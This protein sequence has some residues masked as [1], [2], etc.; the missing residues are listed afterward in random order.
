M[1]SGADPVINT[2]FSCWPWAHHWQRWID[3]DHGKLIS[4]ITHEPIGQFITQERRC[5]RCEKVQLRVAVG[6]K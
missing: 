5:N 2:D 3:I 6:R 4:G 1:A